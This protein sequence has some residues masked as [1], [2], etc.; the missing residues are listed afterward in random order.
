MIGQLPNKLTVSGKDYSINSDF[1]VALLIF[2]A[3]DDIELNDFEKG[4]VCLECLFKQVP[5]N[6]DEAFE[7]AVW[8]LDGGDAPKSEKSPVPILN[9]KQDESL[10]FPAV[11][12]VAGCETRSV[13]Y[14]HWWTFLGLFNEIGEG[15]FSQVINIRAKR[16]KGKPLEKWEREFYNEHKEQIDIKAKLT[17]QEKVEEEWLKNLIGI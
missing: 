6:T 13:P 4:V 3:F 10:I 17:P 7:K 9:W 14:I 11:N 1:R 5:E 8:F 15:L 2:E 16:A 12:K